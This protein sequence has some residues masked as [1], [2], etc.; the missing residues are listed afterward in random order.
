MFL[1]LGNV[2]ENK[3]KREKKK[4]LVKLSRVDRDADAV[5]VRIGSR[6]K[7][8]AENAVRLPPVTATGGKAT[9][10]AESV[11]QYDAGNNYVEQPQNILSLIRIKKVN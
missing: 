5:G 4:G 11:R 2:Y 1:Y 9:E 8:N 7:Q 10:A 3:E 6:G